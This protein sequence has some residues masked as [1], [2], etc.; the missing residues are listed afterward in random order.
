MSD[1]VGNP[2][3]RLFHE[4]AHISGNV[5]IDAARNCRSCYYNTIRGCNIIGSRSHLILRNFKKKF[6][7]SPFKSLLFSV[8]PSVRTTERLL[9]GYA[10]YCEF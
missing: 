1:L 5:Y 3:D 4:A 6:V 9:V 8:R 7:T 10:Y 2:E